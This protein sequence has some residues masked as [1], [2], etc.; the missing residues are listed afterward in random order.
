VYEPADDAVSASEEKQAK[1]A[2]DAVKAKAAAAAKV[3]YYGAHYSP[4]DGL[5]HKPYGDNR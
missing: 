3:A 2:D 5:V 1:A 4:Y